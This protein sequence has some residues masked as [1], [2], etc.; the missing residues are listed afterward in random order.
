MRQF[1]EYNKVDDR[2]STDIKKHWT[3]TIGRGSPY[4]IQSLQITNT[5]LPWIYIRVLII[6]C[7][8]LLIV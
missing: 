3:M 1:K 5:K 8:I 6:K 4:V 2:V 7:T